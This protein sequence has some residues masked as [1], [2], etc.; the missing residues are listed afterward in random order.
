MN[1][2]CGMGLPRLIRNH[3]Q[4]G[5]G[6]DEL[7]MQGSYAPCKCLLGNVGPRAKFLK[8]REELILEIELVD[9]KLQQISQLKSKYTNQNNYMNFWKNLMMQL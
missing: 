9:Y 4:S 5:G 7:L 1:K 8:I 6:G 3:H 2:V